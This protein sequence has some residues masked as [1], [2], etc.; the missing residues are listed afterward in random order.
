[1]DMLVGFHGD[2]DKLDAAAFRAH[3]EEADTET[4]GGRPL[5]VFDNHDNV[6]S[7]D[8]YG[9]GVHNEAIA[10]TIA[11]VLY[12]TSATAMTWEGAEIGMVTTTP[13]RK[14]DV[15]DPI[16]ITGWPKEKRP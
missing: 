1:M 7:W 14:E 15:K 16:G 12:T 10:R 2:H 4:H 5:F 6:R 8:R 9:D 13:T 11:A 3:I